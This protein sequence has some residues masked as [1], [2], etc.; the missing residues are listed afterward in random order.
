MEWS[1]LKGHPAGITTFFIDEGID[2]GAQ[3]VVRESVD[4]S[5]FSEVSAAKQF[6]FSL[7][8]VMF[9]KALEPLQRSD[10][11]G[12][13]YQKPEDGRRYYVMSNLFTE[14]VGQMLSVSAASAMR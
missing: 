1:L 14:V 13:D 2:T 5:S 4:L 11:A 7:N 3:L 12:V 8:G 10:A 6:L 9:A